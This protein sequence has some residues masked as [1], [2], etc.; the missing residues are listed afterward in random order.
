MDVAGEAAAQH[1]GQPSQR[2]MPDAPVLRPAPSAASWRHMHASHQRQMSS[3]SMSSASDVGAWIQQ[4]MQQSYGGQYSIDP[5]LL[6][7]M[8]QMQDVQHT[9]H[10]Q[11]VQYAQHSQHAQ[12]QPPPLH[13]CTSTS[14]VSSQ[15]S[16]PF[17][18][19][20]D[21]PSDASISDLEGY[22]FGFGGSFG[23]NSNTLHNGTG[24]NMLPAQLLNM[25]QQGQRSLSTGAVLTVGSMSVDPNMFRPKDRA[26]SL[27]GAGLAIDPNVLMQG[28]AD[29]LATAKPKRKAPTASH[30]V[31]SAQAG[32]PM[33]KSISNVSAASGAVTTEDEDDGVA[34]GRKSSHARKQKPNHIPRPRNAFILFRKHVVDAKLIPAS[35]EIRHQ[36]V[37]VIVAKMWAEASQEQKEEFNELAR[38]EKEEHQKK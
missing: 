19:G 27:G 2:S 18:Y 37:S 10:A 6:S 11:H 16:N 5:S 32:K 28:T 8:S 36:N 24:D 4:P 21:V 14:S 3:S 35:V 20:F 13:R 31:E 7:Q 9:Q 33:T 15:M 30:P 22:D 34:G 23:G 26:T 17:E 29:D 12:L 1:Y 38:I 25:P